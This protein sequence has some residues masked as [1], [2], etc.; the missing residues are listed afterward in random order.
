MIDP[1][2]KPHELNNRG[3]ALWAQGHLAE[4][5]ALFRRAVALQP[6]MPEAYNNLGAALRDQA[7]LDE[8]LHCFRRAILLRP[9]YA[10]AH[11]NL[12][13]VMLASGVM[14]LGWEEY[15]WRWK[16]PDM[17]AS[18]AALHPPQWRGEPGAGRTLLVHAEQGL[19]DAVQF[20]R[21]ATQAASRGLRVTLQAPAS[22]VRL[23]R[24]LPGVDRV[25]ETGVVPPVSD[26]HCPMLSLPLAFGTTVATIPAPIGYLRADPAQARAAGERL[27]EQARGRLRVGLAWA[28]NPALAADRRR[29]IRPKALAPLSGLRAVQLVNLQRGAEPPPGLTLIDPMPDSRDLADTAALIANLDLVVAAD[30]VVAH[31][32]AALGKPVWLLDRYDSCWRWLVGREDSPWYPTMRIYRQ[33]RPGEWAPVLQR[34]IRD[35]D[36]LGAR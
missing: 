33:E 8:A 4:A 12:A 23:L 20:C 26:L 6:A 21:Y 36:S 10:M 14:P 30:T 9:D 32:A 1:R 35:L 3:A 11:K 25:V 16:L 34:I 19:G 5:E 22:L 27:A 28:G 7:R 2:A 15:E 13:M 29:S 24:T 17:A 18:L 31:L